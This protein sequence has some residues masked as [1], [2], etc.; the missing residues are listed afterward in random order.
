M[1]FHLGL[2]EF[3]LLQLLDLKQLAQRHKKAV[4]P[5]L[6]IVQDNFARAFQRVWIGGCSAGV[7]K[8]FKLSGHRPGR[9]TRLGD[10]FVRLHLFEFNADG[11]GRILGLWLDREVAAD[12]AIAR[13]RGDLRKIQ[14]VRIVAQR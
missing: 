6:A 10:D 1:I 4:L 11:E 5:D 14:P 7:Q 12:L 13:P 9:A 8:T 2:I 3:Q